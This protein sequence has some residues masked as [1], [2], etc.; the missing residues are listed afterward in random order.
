MK[1]NLTT[2]LCSLGYQPQT[3]RQ[4]LWQKQGEKTI[5]TV[6]V[7][8]TEPI[9]CCNMYTFNNDLLLSLDISLSKCP[10][11]FVYS[12]LRHLTEL[13]DGGVPAIPKGMK[14]YIP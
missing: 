5:I 2:F 13:L 6:L 8:D 12:A 7:T 14:P 1:S 10:L 4:N 11:D 9:A 3:S